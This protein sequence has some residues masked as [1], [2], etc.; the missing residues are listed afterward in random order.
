MIATQCFSIRGASVEPRVY[1]DDAHMAG[2]IDM[3]ANIP[4]E[5]INRVE[6]IRSG[7]VIRVYT[8][9][10]MEWAARHNYR[11]PPLWLN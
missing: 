9:N 8:D 6:V 4:R 2:G 11:P 1:I 7:S 5:E 3:L 10:F